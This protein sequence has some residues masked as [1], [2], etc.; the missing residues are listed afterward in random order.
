MEDP[1]RLDC[2]ELRDSGTDQL[3][4][5]SAVGALCAIPVVREL[6]KNITENRTAVFRSSAAAR[7]ICGTAFAVI[8]DVARTARS[9]EA[10]KRGIAKL[11]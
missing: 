9:K 7:D 11:K 6:C 8:I 2:V 4:S 3:S 5:D 1:I 10:E